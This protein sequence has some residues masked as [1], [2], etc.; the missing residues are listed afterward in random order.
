VWNLLTDLAIQGNIGRL[1]ED[2]LLNSDVAPL[3]MKL[4][5]TYGKLDGLDG[6]GFISGWEAKLPS[7]VFYRLLLN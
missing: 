1:T 5:L 7:T 6:S 4:L 3:M 2:S